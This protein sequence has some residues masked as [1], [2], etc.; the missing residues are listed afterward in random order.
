MLCKEKS[1]TYFPCIVPSLQTQNSMDSDL[2]SDRL[3]YEGIRSKPGAQNRE[4]QNLVHKT[5]SIKSARGP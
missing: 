1:E 4:R 5:A 3:W 2:G